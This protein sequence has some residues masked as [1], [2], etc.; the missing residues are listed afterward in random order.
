MQSALEDLKYENDLFNQIILRLKK[1][2]KILEDDQIDLLAP[3]EQFI[4][5]N[6]KYIFEHQKEYDQEEL[7]AFCLE[8]VDLHKQ[9]EEQINTLKSNIE[10]SEKNKKITANKI[11]TYNK[12][13]NLRF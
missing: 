2:I 3:E 4:S 7:R 5:E 10:Q 1:M 6:V 9:F 11:F 13:N 8:Y 12:M